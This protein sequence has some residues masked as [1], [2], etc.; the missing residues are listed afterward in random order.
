MKI[1]GYGED[2]LTLWALKN[3][4]DEIIPKDEITKINKI[5]YR[6]SFGR[7]GKG[8]SNFGEMDF[9]ILTLETIY[10]GESKWDKLGKSKAKHINLLD[11][12]ILRHKIMAKYIELWEPS[13]GWESLKTKNSDFMKEFDKEVPDEEK[14][15]ACNLLTLLREIGSRKNICNI[16]LYFHNGNNQLID[17]KYTKSGVDFLIRNIDYSQ[18]EEAKKN[19]IQLEII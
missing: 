7:G 8:K 10:L 5:F 2:A 3:K 14:G 1:Y 11:N 16:L 19:L 12:Q 9:I 17:S 15:L 18:A 6:P 4:L 13:N